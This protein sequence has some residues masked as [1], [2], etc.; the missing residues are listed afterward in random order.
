MRS[1]NR[2]ASSSKQKIAEKNK[3]PNEIAK[4]IIGTKVRVPDR[5]RFFAKR[6]GAILPAVAS[7]V[8]RVSDDTFKLE[9]SFFRR[10]M[11]LLQSELAGSGKPQYEKFTPSDWI[12][13]ALVTVA[14]FSLPE[15]EVDD[16]LWP[17]NKP[18]AE[19]WKK[20]PDS[21]RLR[22]GLPVG[23]TLE[24]TG[25]DGRLKH[26]EPGDSHNPRIE[27]LIRISNNRQ[28]LPELTIS[29][30][31]EPVCDLVG[32]LGSFADSH[33]EKTAHEKAGALWNSLSKAIAVCLKIENPTQGRP[34]SNSG[35]D[36]ALLHDHEGLTWRKVADILCKEDHQHDQKCADNFRI[37]AQHYWERQ[38]EKYLQTLPANSKD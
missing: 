2:P 36:A 1:R 18:I 23:E 38:R 28:S 17:T 11:A 6:W 10:F 14:D 35:D 34:A 29:L 24:Y 15:P 31:G 33:N 7:K 4:L 26:I 8:E 5:E 25:K 19:A 27:L 20:F 21:P 12:A 13:Q 3:I 37:Q 30:K 32:P 16:T 9:K 22:W